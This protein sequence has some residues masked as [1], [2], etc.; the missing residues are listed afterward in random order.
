[1]N[2]LI[3]DKSGIYLDCTLGTGGHFKQI[4]KK[5]NND[6]T[7]IGF[8]VDPL[9][10]QYCKETIKAAQTTLYINSNF[11]NIRKYTFKNGYVKINGI[12]MDLGIS[13][14]ALEDPERGLAFRKNGPL[15]MRFSPEIKESA[16]DFINN[17]EVD[18]IKRIL[19]RYGEEK[20]SGKIVREIEKVRAVNQIQTTSQLANI[21][22]KFTPERF[23]NKA[24][25]R[26]FQA[27]RI[28]INKELDVLKNALEQTTKML[29]PGGRLIIISYH[30]IED[31]IVKKFLKEQIANCVCPPEFPICNCGHTT[32]FKN[33]TRKIILPTE[34]E[35]KAN[36]RARSAKLRAME[37]L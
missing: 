1:M 35:I 13:S 6:A 36:N 29:L 27:I 19:W 23:H 32:N 25:S 16:A 28:H 11:E 3:T 24:C 12:L 14:F 30:S 17:A 2:Y 34:K 22:K 26:V 20:A 31:R 37:K 7:V 21:I 9:A 10:I 5:T 4:L 18:D 33:L 8:D 15:D